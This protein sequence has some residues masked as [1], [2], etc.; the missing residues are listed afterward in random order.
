METPDRTTLLI[1]TDGSGR[2]HPRTGGYA[3]RF[4]Y[5]NEQGQEQIEDFEPQGFRT[6]T[7]NEM[8]L[9]ACIDALEKAWRFPRLES[10]RGIKIFTDSEYVAKGYGYA[11]HVWLKTKWKK[12]D[13]A[14]VLNANLWK[15]LLTLTGRFYSKRI[16]INIQQ[17]RGKTNIHNK[18]VD[19]MAKRSSKSPTNKQF[20]VVNVRR[21]KFKN[22]GTFTRQQL[23]GQTLSI[24]V[25][26]DRRLSVQKTYQYKCEI[27]SRQHSL[28]KQCGALFGEMLL[29]AGHH[30]LIKISDDEAANI[31]TILRE[32]VKRIKNEVGVTDGSK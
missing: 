8:E 31:E 26:A 17:E 24:R 21:K 16:Y 2:H 27:I 1:Q 15:K 6:A 7:S 32:H 3:Y 13:G 14:P 30:Y 29:K 10:I 18:A 5:L 20:S 25:V 22:A 9:Y 28:Y 11:K 23:R 12:S 19:K 4:I